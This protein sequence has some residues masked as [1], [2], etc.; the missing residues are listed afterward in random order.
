MDLERRHLIKALLGGAVLTTTVGCAQAL[1]ASNVESRRKSLLVGCTQD[2]EGDY[3]VTALNKSGEI[4]YRYP[5]Q[6]RGH[7][8]AHRP[9]GNSHLAVFSRRPGDFI[10]II[11]TRSGTH[12]RTINAQSNRFFYGH[13]VYSQDGEVLYTTEAISGTCEGIIGVYQVKDN[14][15]K[16]NE[17]AVGGIGPHQIAR[18]SNDRLVVAVG[19]IRT[20][21]RTKMNLDSMAPSLCYYQQDGK[22]IDKQELSEHLLS[23]RH[24]DVADD[25]TVYFAQQY[26]DTDPYADALVGA[27][28]LGSSPQQLNAT[29]S[30]WLSCKGYIGSVIATQESLFATSPRGNL[31]LEF[32]RQT[33]SLSNKYRALDVCGIA[34]NGRDVA[35][36][37]G[38]GEMQLVQRHALRAIHHCALQWDNHLIWV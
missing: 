6:A 23:I 16:V 37:T 3:S 35:L 17:F 4:A 28:Q 32:D 15:R 1:G 11:D 33:L 38:F 14:Y 20:K 34:T 36:S 19:G 26:Q 30:D 7:G 27:H 24:L 9:Q 13:G 21:G 22:L 25:D 5:L 12:I 10:E 29:S 2:A 8:F 31:V 18:L